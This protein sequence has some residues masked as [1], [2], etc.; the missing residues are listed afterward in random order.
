M[1]KRTKKRNPVIDEIK[2][3]ETEKRQKNIEKVAI[4]EEKK[5]DKVLF[6][7]WWTLRSPK[8]PKKHKKE[9]IKAD[10]IGRGLS[11]KE[12]MA[13]FDKALMRYGIKL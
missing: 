7:M 4:K 6:D 11:D 10:F 12:E 13:M 5:G 9:I 8:I 3:M 2:K 1:P